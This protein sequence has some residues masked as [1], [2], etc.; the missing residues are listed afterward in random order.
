[1]YREEWYKYRTSCTQNWLGS[2][3]T[4]PWTLELVTLNISR[5]C[6]HQNVWLL[7]LF[8]KRIYV[9][10]I[11]ENLY[12]IYIYVYLYMF[13]Y[14]HVP[15]CMSC[16]KA[17]VVI[18]GRAHW[19]V[20]KGRNVSATALSWFASDNAH[21]CVHLYKYISIYYF[22]NKKIQNGKIFLTAFLFQFISISTSLHLFLFLYLHIY[23]K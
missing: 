21:F 8:R 19:W 6:C 13:I 1:M 11:I 4:A 14:I 7:S 9:Y 20:L 10:K 22:R 16:H 15:K 3:P 17:T 12:N 2:L 18:I 5:V 23:T